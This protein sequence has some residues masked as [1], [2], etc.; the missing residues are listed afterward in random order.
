MPRRLSSNGVIVLTRDQILAALT[1]GSVEI[2]VVSSGDED[3]PR[4]AGGRGRGRF[5]AL[6]LTSFQWRTDGRRSARACARRAGGCV[7]QVQAS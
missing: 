5:T 7:R 2:A 3:N 4:Q 1:D 6:P